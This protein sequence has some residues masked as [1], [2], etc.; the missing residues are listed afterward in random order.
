M[1]AE[2]RGVFLQAL[3]DAL[4]DL[5]SIVGPELGAHFENIKPDN[6]YDG[7]CYFETIAFLREHISP[8]AMALVGSRFVEELKTKLPVLGSGSPREMAYRAAEIYGAFVRGSEGGY[9]R[10]ESYEPGRAVIAECSA[11]WNPALSAGIIRGSLE[12]AGAYNV[13]IELLS[14]RQEGA[15]ENRYLVEWIHPSG[16]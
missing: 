9:W 4:P 7:R 1:D 16:E 12:N 11:S 6:W 5:T 3:K 2:V 8:Q 14:N 13:R 15:P 10:L